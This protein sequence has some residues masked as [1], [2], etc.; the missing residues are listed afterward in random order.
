MPTDTTPQFIAAPAT[1]AGSRGMLQGLYPAEQ[2]MILLT[3]C[4]GILAYVLSHLFNQRVAWD[5]FLISFA[6]AIGLILLGIYVRQ[7]KNMPR[8]AMAAIGAGVYI[9]FSGVIT[10]LIYLRFPFQTPMIDPQLMQL[11]ALLFGYDWAAFTG[12]LAA[13]PVLGKALGWVYGT[14]LMQLFAVLF[15]LG[16]LGRITDLHRV[17]ITGILSLL[18]AVALWWAWPSIGPSAYITL[19]DHVEAALGLVHGE[20]AGNRLM[21]MAET[22]NPI[23]TPQIIMGTIAFPSYHTV[24]V[25]LAVAFVRGTWAFWP[26]MVLNGAMLPAI[27]SHGGHHVSDMIGGVAVFALACWLATRLVPRSAADGA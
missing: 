1:L 17:L 2:L 21:Q 5:A 8:A 3:G 24:M 14:S 4:I 19:P 23:I 16:F 15:L 11:D 12:A 6:P 10:I 27:L 26:L 18:I 25:C 20:V 7:R 22:G 9:G 13:Y